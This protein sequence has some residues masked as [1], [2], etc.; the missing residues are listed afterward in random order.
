MQCF[1]FY[2]QALPVALLDH[3]IQLERTFL[4]DNRHFSKLVF[5]RKGTERER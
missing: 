5:Q 1:G 2:A 4:V 3:L